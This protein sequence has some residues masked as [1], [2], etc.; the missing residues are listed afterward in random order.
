MTGVLIAVS[1]LRYELLI[2]KVDEVK[3]TSGAWLAI[4]SLTLTS[5]IIILI[6][7][8]DILKFLSPQV[9]G[10]G[11]R[12]WGIPIFCLCGGIA[13]VGL[14]ITLRRANFELNAIFRSAQSVLFL[15]LAFVF[16]SLTLVDSIILAGICVSFAI[17][18]YLYQT[19][20]PIRTSE[21]W[22]L[23]KSYKKFPLYL[24]PTTF[25]DAAA[26]AAPIFIV[27]LSY[28]AEAAGNYFQ[29]QRIAGAPL[30]LAAMVAGQ[31]FLKN[32][33]EAYRSGQSLG[34]FLRKY[35]LIMIFISG[36]TILFLYIGGEYT[37][38]ALLGSEWR[39]DSYF[40]ILVTVPLM[41]R[42]CVSTVSSILITCNSVTT[43]SKWQFIYFM[44]SVCVL[45]IT[46]TKFTLDHFLIIFALHELLHYSIYFFM[47]SVVS[48]RYKPSTNEKLSI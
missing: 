40:I 12:I 25:L 39:V 5:F 44:S 30:V 34:G 13:L 27:N 45:Y 22:G 31:L 18:L 3:V 1:C 2:V 10:L 24:V 17:F 6:V 23:A 11:L 9:D 15:T 47:C 37:F 4:F 8:F 28:G 7:I 21:I 33:S 46:S 14:Q 26:L 43:A 20:K 29:I 32:S 42:L 19:T 38:R 41:V 35:F 16:D 36:I 48:K